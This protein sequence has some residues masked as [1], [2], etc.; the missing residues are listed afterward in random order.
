MKKN[1][2]KS[3]LAKLWKRR[4][5]SVV[6][7]LLFYFYGTLVLAQNN[8]I[9]GRVTDADTGE[10]LIGVTV[11]VRGTTQGTITDMS[12]SYAL[13]ASNGATLEFSFVGYKTESH[14]IGS[15]TQV[16]VT[17]KSQ[18]YEIDDVV[19][20]GYGTVKK[21][22]LTGAVGSVSAKQLK[23]VTVTNPQLALQGRVPGVQVTQTDFSPSGGLEIRIRGTRSFQ[24]SND[25]LY[26]VDGMMLSTEIGRAHV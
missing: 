11:K 1:Q 25:P 16:N 24:A 5:L 19:V 13:N 21:S 9:T 18:S 2:F 7:L 12:G 15:K 10:P 3:Y 6:S 17:L 20:I 23:D 4:T 14:T 26:V 22:D 8:V